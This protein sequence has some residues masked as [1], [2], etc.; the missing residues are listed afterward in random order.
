MDKPQFDRDKLESN[1]TKLELSGMRSLQKRV[2]S[3]EIMITE[4]DKSGRFSIL[5]SSQYY[6]AGQK[7]TKNDQ[8][9]T[10]DQVKL[11][12]KTVNDHNILLRKIFGLGVNWGH[13]DRISNSMTDKGEVVAPLYL[14]IK[15]HKGWSYEEGSPPPSRPACSGI[16]GFNRHISEILSLVLEPLGHAMGGEDIDSTGGLLAKIG[17]LNEALL[18]RNRNEAQMENEAA[19]S[20]GQEPVC[21]E[22]DKKIDSPHMIVHNSKRKII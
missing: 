9:I 3:N 6:Q 10:H 17:S 14:L 18:D 4:T 7:H 13:E 19:D 15:D 12:Q 5:K 2:L 8:V 21:K 1:L 22:C 16:K 20:L 11:I